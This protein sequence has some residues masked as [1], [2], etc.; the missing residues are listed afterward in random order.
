MKTLRHI[1]ATA[2]A[3]TLLAFPA[4]ADAISLTELSTYLNGLKTAK[5]G[6]TQINDDGSITTGKLV[7][8]RPWKI[9]FEY[10]G[11]DTL[12]L[13]SALSV[14]IFDPKGNP[15]PETY[16]LKRTPLKLILDR[17]INL[18]QDNMVV[19]HS[20]DGTAT[21][22]IAQDPKNPELGTLEL[23]F[24]D[25]PVQLRQWVVNDDSGAATT[26]V[27]GAMETGM[28]ISNQVFDIDREVTRRSR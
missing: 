12:V 5:A 2:A 25:N 6:F 20:Y 13:A 4:A 19:G 28:T 27:L 24:T 7:L 21:K 16:P 1:L 26:V 14:A 17:N 9:R 11:D 8:K 18:S 23:V 10:D 15:R 22:L 3:S